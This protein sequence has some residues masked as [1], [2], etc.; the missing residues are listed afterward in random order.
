MTDK[1]QCNN[2]IKLSN[3]NCLLNNNIIYYC[4]LQNVLKARSYRNYLLSH[5]K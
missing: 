5:I 4:N 1:C 3:Y 2:I